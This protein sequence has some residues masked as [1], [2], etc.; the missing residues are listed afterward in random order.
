VTSKSYYKSEINRLLFS[1]SLL[2]FGTLRYQWKF[3]SLKIQ[4]NFIL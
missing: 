1:Q 4:L 2:L 3:L